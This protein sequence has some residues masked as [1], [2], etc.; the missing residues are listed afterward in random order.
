MF[1]RDGA[2]DQIQKLC[3]DLHHRGIKLSS[4][5]G[6]QSIT[7]TGPPFYN[8]EQPQYS[9]AVPEGATLVINPVWSKE[10]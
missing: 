5:F 8:N 6:G 10:G 2:K 3:N 1:N 9:K 4:D 7:P